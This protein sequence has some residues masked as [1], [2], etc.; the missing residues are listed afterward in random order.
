MKKLEKELKRLS[1]G[2]SSPALSPRGGEGEEGGD[3]ISPARHKQMAILLI[4]ERNKLIDKLLQ[5]Q[6]RSTQL[7]ATLKAV[8][9]APAGD[10]KGNGLAEV[11]SAFSNV[12]EKLAFENCLG[13]QIYPPGCE[14]DMFMLGNM[15]YSQPCCI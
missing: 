9:H 13:S 11:V 3:G 8:S 4:K 6:Q 12:S 1:G 2:S 15:S 5:L 10:Q 14:S 7:E